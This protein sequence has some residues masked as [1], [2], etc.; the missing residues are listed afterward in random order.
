MGDITLEK[1]D[2]TA[3]ID[4]SRGAVLT[5]GLKNLSPISPLPGK[6]TLY[7]NTVD[8]I[9]RAWTITGF[10]S[11]ANWQQ[12]RQDLDEAA[13]T[14]HLP[15]AGDGQ[16]RLIWGKEPGDVNDYDFNVAIVNITYRFTTKRP[17]TATLKYVEFTITL[18]EVGVIGALNPP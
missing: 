8:L 4:L 10:L 14:W 16:S 3:T 2:A 15:P 1:P 18:Q 6:N 13:Q 7:L 9:T 12:E 5:Q 11:V 17:G